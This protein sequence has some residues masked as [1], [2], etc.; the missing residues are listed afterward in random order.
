[1]T[2]A[3]TFIAHRGYSGNYPENTLIAYQ[4]AFD[5]GARLVELDIQLTNDLTPVL[6]HDLSLKRMAGIDTNICEVSA[7]QLTHYKASYPKAFG[8]QF[9]DNGFTTLQQF[10]QWLAQHSEV[11]AFIEIKQ[12]SIDHFGLTAVANAVYHD[13]ET[14]SVGSQAI[15][16]SYNNAIIEKMRRLHGLQIGWVL[17]TLN[18]ETYKTL[19][20]LKPDFA[21]CDIDFLSNNNQNLLKGQWRWVA[22]NADN[23]DTVTAIENRG[24]TWIETNEIGTLLTDTKLAHKLSVPSTSFRRSA[25]LI[26]Q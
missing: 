19:E 26:A 22:Y 8:H 3:L 18:H 5:C 25:F 12:E 21:F 4:A 24:I 16:I 15:L 20:V 13:I 1:M 2:Q 6:H 10:C 23:T 17:P 14:S 9:I 11:T 7:E